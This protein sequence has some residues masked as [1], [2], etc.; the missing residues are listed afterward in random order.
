MRMGRGRT[1]G[2]EVL[3][4]IARSLSDL[5]VD[6]VKRGVEEAL[7][8]SVSPHDI[9]R[10]SLGRG[11]EVVGER[12][13]RDEYFLSDLIF[14]SAIM[15]EAMAI[16]R[17]HLRSVVTGGSGVVVIGTVEGDLHDIGKNLV[18]AMLRSAGYEV[19]DL[20]VDVSPERFVEG[21]RELKPNL[22]CMSALLS[23]TMPKMGETIGALEEASLR[24]GVKVLVGG[25]CVDEGI[26]VRMGADGYAED[27]WKA[28][29]RARRVLGGENI[30]H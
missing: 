16:L 2:R 18:A 7:G 11:M 3:S 26:A 17:P 28:V 12:Y 1:R 9:V 14:A 21:V 19:H 10:E 24:E 20:G 25:R 13:E 15:D 23:V 22:V 4:S 27:A 8:A 30:L 6:G 29:S 5:D